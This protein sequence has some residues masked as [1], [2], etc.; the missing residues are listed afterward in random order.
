MRAE[1]KVNYV[2]VHGGN[3]STLTWNKLAGSNI[4]TPDGTLGGQVW[5]PV[6]SILQAQGHQVFAPTLKDEHQSSLTEH[7]QEI[8]NLINANNL[9]NVVL[10]GH[11]YGGMIITG[12][13]ACIPTKI[14]TLVYVDAAL[15]DPGQSLFDLLTLGM[16]NPLSFKGLEPAPPYVEKLEFNP[17]KTSDL[18]KI[19]ILCTES[20]FTSVTHLAW[21]KIGSSSEEKWTYI[22]LPSS[23]VPMA[24]MPERFSLI[25]LEIQSNIKKYE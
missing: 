4:H 21:E 13:A 9:R 8:C 15:P 2:L 24:S 22:E 11:S 6:V 10:V 12:V 16:D 18:P 5:D 20:E 25:L 3:M 17:E 19:Y 14:S 7:I 1:G 23:H